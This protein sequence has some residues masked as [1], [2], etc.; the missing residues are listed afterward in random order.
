M[1]S[2]RLLLLTT[3][4]NAE[5]IGAERNVAVT[6]RQQPLQKEPLFTTNI[7]LTIKT[8]SK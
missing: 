6:H 3:I 1:F 5:W 2:K 4:E 7:Y 8:P